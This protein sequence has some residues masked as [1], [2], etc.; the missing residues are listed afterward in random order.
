MRRFTFKNHHE[1]RRWQRFRLGQRFRV[2]WRV[3][4]R[5]RVGGSQHYSLRRVGIWI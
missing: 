1:Q 2:R 3:R 5:Q 4:L